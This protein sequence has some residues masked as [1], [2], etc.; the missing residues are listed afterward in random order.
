[1]ATKRRVFVSFD[2]DDT[3]QVNGFLGLRNLLDGLEFYNH[4]LD[5]R[6]EGQS[7]EYKRRVIREQ[8]IRPASVT[9]VLIGRRTAY[10]GWVV[11]EIA[12]SVEEGNGL[13]GIKLPGS[14]GPIPAGLPARRVF[15]WDPS[16]FLRLIEWAAVNR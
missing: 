14:A 12:A 1:M 2:H 10:S 16:T 8:Y 15:P 6:I 7:D 5:H 11:W 13:L 9:V 4:K 3:D